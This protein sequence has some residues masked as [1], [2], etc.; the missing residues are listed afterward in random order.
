MIEW[1]KLCSNSKADRQLLTK[2][3]TWTKFCTRRG[4]CLGCNDLFLTR[5]NFKAIFKKKSKYTW[6]GNLLAKTLQN[7]SKFKSPI[8]PH[9]LNYCYGWPVIIQDDHQYGHQRSPSTLKQI[10]SFPNFL[11][12]PKFSLRHP[13]HYRGVR[14]LY[15]SVDMC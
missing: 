15:S 6:S 4:I 7:I 11:S 14:E 2:D 12:F 10:W 5:V 13:V 8:F 3:F 1:S 9:L